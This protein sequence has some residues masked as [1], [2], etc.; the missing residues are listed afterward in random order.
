MLKDKKK[1]LITIALLLIATFGV[2][3]AAYTIA[4]VGNND[5]VKQ[6]EDIS[7]TGASLSGNLGFMEYSSNID[8]I[9]EDSNTQTDYM[10]NIVNIVPS[11]LTGTRAITTYAVSDANF[12]KLVID[13]H[14]EKNG[15]MKANT[16]Q[17]V[18]LY[19]NSQVEA[20]T[21][22]SQATGISY[23]DDYTVASL[24]GDAD[25]VYIESPTENSYT[26]SYAM[27][28]SV[29]SYLH[30]NYT[31]T[32]HKAIILDKISSGGTQTETKT[33]YR[34]LI[35]QIC[36]R[37]LYSPVFGWDKSQEAADFLAGRGSSHYFSKVLT[38]SG[39]ATGKILVLKGPSGD[40]WIT[41]RFATK[42]NK[43]S[44]YYGRDAWLPKNFSINYVDVSTLTDPSLLEGYEFIIIE[45]SAT[46]VEID[47][48]K[49]S[50]YDAL[51]SLANGTQYIIYD[52]ANVDPKDNSGGNGGNKYA[53]LLS[54]LIT[55]EGVARYSYVL[56]VDSGFF[57]ADAKTTNGADLI[58]DLIN[59]SNY[60]GS[61]NN[62]RNG[63]K[64][65][66]LE[67]QPCYPIDTDLAKSKP[68]MTNSALA[69][70]M[71]LEGN[72]YTN[73]GDVLMNTSVDEANGSEYYA[74][75]MT[76][77]KVAKATGLSY[78][79]IQIDQMSTDE[80]ISKKDVVLDTY[81]LVYIGGNTSALTPFNMRSDFAG[82]YTA[83]SEYAVYA[84]SKLV[85]SFDMYTHTGIATH[86]QQYGSN[87]SGLG[88]DPYGTIT[89][90]EGIATSILL[91][92]NDITTLKLNE[93]KDY[94]D[95]GMPIIF[96][97]KVSEAFEK[98]Y[99]KSRIEKLEAKN[100]DPD[101][102]MF[103][104]LDYAYWKHDPSGYKGVDSTLGD[105]VA[106]TGNPAANIL[107]DMDI[108][109]YDR[110]DDYN[111][112]TDKKYGSKAGEYVTVFNKKAADQV[113]DVIQ[114][115][116]TRPSLVVSSSP[117]DYSR[118][119]A[120]TYNTKK[121]NK[122]IIKANVIA[123]ADVDNN[124]ATQDGQVTCKLVLY[125][126]QDG[127]GSFD[128]DE[129][130]DGKAGNLKTVTCKEADGGKSETIE[131]TY[132]FPQDDFYGLVSWKLVASVYDA[133]VT[134][135]QPCDVKSGFAYYKREDEVEKK[136]VRVLQIMP[137]SEQSPGWTTGTQDAHTLYMCTECQLAA[138]KA[139]YNI[140]TQAANV[141]HTNTTGSYS[142][143]ANINNI[144]L[145]E[146]KF[147]IVEYDTNGQKID[148]HDKNGADDWDSNFADELDDDYE[149]DLDILLIDEFHAYSKIIEANTLS[150][151][152]TLAKM[153][154][155]NGIERKDEE[156]NTITPIL[157]ASGNAITWVDYY[158][159]KA[160]SFYDQWQAAL[161]KL[162]GSS[163]VTN[164]E[165]FLKNLQ[166]D[167]GDGKQ[168]NVGI[169]DAEQIQQ[170]IDHEA[171]YNYFLYYSGYYTFDAK[172]KAYYDEW[173]TL[174]DQVVK[175]HNLYKEY[176]C[177][178]STKDKWLGANY[179]MVVL[180]FAEDFGG[181]D[182]TVDECAA[183]K[184]YIND[185]GSLLTTHDSTTRYNNAGS[186]N[187]TNELRSVFGIDRYHATLDT[188]SQLTTVTDRTMKPIYLKDP[189][190][191]VYYGPIYL[192]NKDVTVKLVKEDEDLKSPFSTPVIYGT[193]SREEG[194]TVSP[195]GAFN[196]TIKLY[197]SEA[198]ADADIVSSNSWGYGNTNSW[199]VCY[200]AQ[201]NMQYA[202]GCSSQ[203][204]IIQ[205]SNPGSSHFTLT[206]SSVTTLRNPVYKFA[207]ARYFITDKAVTGSATLED[208][209][210]WQQAVMD[211]ANVGNGD[212][213]LFGIISLIGT[214]DSIGIFETASHLN[215][216]YLYAE[217]NLQ[218]S[219]TYSIGV[220]YS[221]T[222]MGG[223]DKAMQVNKGIV[224]TYPFTLGE[225]LTISP[226]HAQT[227]AT[228][229]EDSDMAVW[230]T[231]AGSNIDG[232][233]GTK[234][235]RSSLYAASPYDGMDNYFLYS[236]QYGKG[237]VHYCGAGHS[238]V[239][240]AEKNN[241]DERMLYVNI[242]VDS[243]R[244]SASRPK[245]TILDKNNKKVTEN[246]KGN[247]KLDSNGNYVYSLD[248]VSDTPEFNFDV[249]FSSLSGGLSKVLVFYD[250]NYDGTNADYSNKYT[251][252]DNHVL[253]HEYTGPFAGDDLD[254]KVKVE[255]NKINVELRKDVFPFTST[256]AEG[257]T[258]VVGDRL[259]LNVKKDKSGNAIDYFKNY[260]SYTYIVVWAEDMNGKTAYQRIKIKLL[261]TL[262]D[263]TDNN[264]IEYP[265]YQFNKMYSLLDITDKSKFNI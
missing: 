212:S 40:D 242:V 224:T 55:E 165:S 109:V 223:T 96:S 72:Y 250:L 95:A 254:Q 88:G 156:G 215:M 231:L 220:D 255:A 150:D 152:V 52:S 100:I 121:D 99:S 11:N 185:G 134:H 249:K 110:N 133:N 31:G 238:V 9:I 57:E 167:V 221:N 130:V 116:V 227:Y 56:P 174:H 216:P 183:V 111:R 66:V 33:T 69:T 131:M 87:S 47:A 181:K 59:G 260:G 106:N 157:D 17:V 125:V 138:Y 25:L 97:D 19:L 28:D 151:G 168:G 219:I 197:D 54:S 214:T 202:G 263:L 89:N 107:W 173:V 252:D 154:N 233:K 91:N 48:A 200:T 226:T 4:G 73:P 13:A 225:N 142:S 61:E 78:N 241:N 84:Q 144:G 53:E 243:V 103:K 139:K 85:T 113:V 247:L 112:N 230:Y 180:G 207:D 147:G 94:I 163:C 30:N 10:Y 172:Y 26:G 102:N 193:Y 3:I 136:D 262:F 21:P 189:T 43:S 210:V 245:I 82:N 146:H 155:T 70:G 41:D 37:Y 35:N 218:D 8:L 14:S 101:S 32:D 128:E 119:D 175:Y 258:V 234:K 81:D 198:D 68:D 126:D 7:Q 203:N 246:T 162:Q 265:S 248:N 117:K 42:E 199:S 71:K 83:I 236:Y 148:S 194:A 261:Q 75:E 213:K 206:S 58:A 240:G 129:I 192:T 166:E 98:V 204:G 140:M 62:G 34:T 108:S 80:F 251:D 201:W 27:T 145:H 135:A 123:N 39:Q 51:I 6:E 20:S 46:K 120:T 170:W 257:N 86:L 5:L 191:E 237:T 1:F 222:E 253:I 105:N 161:G 29:Y 65:R 228:D 115:A 177:Y 50:V 44:I 171:Y 76:P 153:D 229:L 239:T 24:L 209:I 179:D 159:A 187:L 92:G 22:A 259:G 169:V 79:Q 149:F 124:S 45:N 196:I 164:M 18:T 49:Q 114:D 63:K 118:G 188:S 256:D 232:G 264:T 90:S 137:V 217:Y 176:S 205:Y 211:Y 178:A 38:G 195:G 122:M 36:D 208:R 184:T 16:V 132:E 2:S 104:L 74:F 190:K 60:R 143:H 186:V 244:N 23:E 127:D 64:F 160:D 15:K 235:S 158:Q 182:L 93:L 141:L 12:K 77:A 67:I